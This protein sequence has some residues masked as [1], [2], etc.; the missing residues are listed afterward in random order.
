MVYTSI[1]LGVAIFGEV[2]TFT[3]RFEAK[4]TVVHF[5]SFKGSRQQM[6]QTTFS[7]VSLDFIKFFYP[8][9]NQDVCSKLNALVL[10]LRLR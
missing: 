7:E 2:H 10:L 6:G 9:L 3:V 1:H 5:T 8:M 4:E